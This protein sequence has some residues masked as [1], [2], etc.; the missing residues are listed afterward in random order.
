MAK[1][2][3]STGLTYLWGKIKSLFVPQTRTVNG[4]SLNADITLTASDVSALP[5][6]TEMPVTILEN[7]DSENKTP[8]RTLDSGTYVLK[9]YFTAY[10]GSTASYTFTSGML[11]SVV[12]TTDMSYI[13]IFYAKSNTI[14]YLE[15]SDTE[16]TRKDA[17]LVNMQSIA[18]KVDSVTASSD[19]EHYPSAKAVY[20]ALLTVTTPAP[21]KFVYDTHNEVLGLTQD[22]ESYTKTIKEKAYNIE[23]DGDI[24]NLDNGCGDSD[25]T[26]YA[27]LPTATTARTGRIYIDT[28]MPTGVTL[29]SFSVSVKLGTNNISPSI[30][31][32]HSYIIKCGSYT[33]KE[34]DFTLSMNGAKITATVTNP[35]VLASPVIVI[36]FVAQTTDEREVRVYG[37]DVQ[38]TYTAT[39]EYVSLARGSK[40]ATEK[41]NPPDKSTIESL[42]S[43][44]KWTFTLKSGS[45]VTKTV[46][47]K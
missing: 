40:I 26:L 37:A 1:Y 13:Q 42:L 3:D 18:A 5:A 9:G 24:T 36:E 23:W 15:I 45:T 47:L 33:L 29:S 19:N 6:N 35:V 41:A 43:S 21:W 8:L 16:V 12:K 30:W 44:E 34:G 25:N 27:T 31:T 7:N 28:Q 4:K 10:T 20:N 39:K 2:L 17:K 14:Q 46:V 38:A 32:T 11:V 22:V